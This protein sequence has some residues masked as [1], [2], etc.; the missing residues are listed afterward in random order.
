MLYEVITTVTEFGLLRI[1]EVLGPTLG[2]LQNASASAEAL[3]QGAL[4]ALDELQP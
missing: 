1:N 2:N 4:T 3:R